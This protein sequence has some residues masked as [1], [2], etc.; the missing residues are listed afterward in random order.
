MSPDHALH[1]LD[2]DF[3]DT[4]SAQPVAGGRMV[5]GLAGTPGRP[6]L[7]WVPGAF[8]GAWCYAHYLRFF[9]ARG[10]ACAALDLPGH[11]G[12]PQTADFARTT[13]AD[14]AACVMAAC[15][16]LCGPV[17]VAG[18]SMGALPALLCAAGRPV[19]GVVLMAPSPPANLA[20]ARALPAVPAGLPVAPP[21]L[22]EIGLRFLAEPGMPDEA[23]RVARRLCA[24]SPEVINDRYRLRVP[25]DPARIQAPG[26]CLEA[27]Q[28][29][30]ER[31][32]PGQDRAVAALFGFDYLLLPGQPHCMMYARGWQQSAQA[33]LDWTLHL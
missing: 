1:H 13:V 10:V 19:A 3:V 7:L 27:G 4:L 33:I 25:V 17:I 12:L 2:F 5:T 29:T 31:H 24:E 11:G 20:G 18:H 6:T 26:L 8:H 28:D 32:P 22:L 30:P 23:A 15:D 16:R 14:L 21:N 9:A